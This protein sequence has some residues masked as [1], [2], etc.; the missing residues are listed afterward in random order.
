[1]T[2]LWHSYVT[3]VTLRRGRAAG[4]ARARDQRGSHERVSEDHSYSHSSLKEDI[5]QFLL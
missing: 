1:M 3:L 4:R 5:V 2:L